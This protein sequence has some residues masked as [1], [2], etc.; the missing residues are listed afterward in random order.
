MISIS[1]ESCVLALNSAALNRRR[2]IQL[3]LGVGLAVY[4]AEGSTDKQAKS[5][6]CEAYSGAGYDCLDDTGRDYK[7]VN[8][9]L[10]AS[11]RLFNKMGPGVVLAWIGRH[12]DSRAIELL[13]DEMELLGFQFISDVLDYC[14]DKPIIKRKSVVKMQMNR[15]SEDREY[16]YRIETPHIKVGIPEEVTVSE[17]ISA[18]KKL[19]TLA[20]QLAKK[21]FIAG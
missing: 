4:A 19:F 12:R 16:A 14:D 20:D 17:L 9:R 18:A 10:N 8:R 6:L 5:I 13:A 1:S 21:Q 11:A 15:R 7:T 3:E 2:A